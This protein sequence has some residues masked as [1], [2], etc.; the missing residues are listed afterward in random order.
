MLLR[1]LV[2]LFN[3]SGVQIHSLGRRAFQAVGSANCAISVSIPRSVVWAVYRITVYVIF[4]THLATCH[5]KSCLFLLFTLLNGWVD[6]PVSGYKYTNG[7]TDSCI[8]W[9]GKR[10]VTS[11]MVR[12]SL[13]PRSYN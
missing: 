13:E 2:Q 3:Y 11:A 5:V 4:R 6:K 1:P 7:P 9:L 12:R 8:L 10:F